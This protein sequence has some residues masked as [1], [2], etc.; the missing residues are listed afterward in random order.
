[1]KR[2]MK[3]VAVIGG[4]FLLFIFLLY[5]PTL[6][7]LSSMRGDY[8]RI[9]SEI[10]QMKNMDGGGK[11]LEETIAKL[12]KRLDVLNSM[13]PSKEEGVLRLLS[14]T[15]SNLKINVTSMTPEKRHIVQEIG[16]ASVN[17][18]ECAIQEMGIKMSVK[19]DYKAF[20]EFVRTVRED[21]P[22]YVKFDSVRMEKTSN[23]K[24]P[25]L[26]IDVEM[27]TYLICSK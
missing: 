22:V 11:S 8:D 4:A 14:Q 3:S 19:S 6:H 1:M 25:V 17:I 23:D 12:N 10:A 21:F 26:N 2:S 20:E 13:F 9:S 27:H 15:A 18:K 5:I 24:H 16:G 7:G